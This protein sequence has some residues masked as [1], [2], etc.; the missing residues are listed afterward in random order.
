MTNKLPTSSKLPS[1]AKPPSSPTILRHAVAPEDVRRRNQSDIFFD[2]YRYKPSN[3]YVRQLLYQVIHDNEFSEKVCCYFGINTSEHETIVRHVIKNELIS[4]SFWDTY[5][6]NGVAITSEIQR[7]YNTTLVFATNHDYIPSRDNNGLAR[8]NYPMDANLQF[9]L[10]NLKSTSCILKKHHTL[11]SSSTLP[12]HV[13]P[14]NTLRKTRSDGL[15]INKSTFYKS[16]PEGCQI[17]SD[18][19][20]TRSE[21]SSIRSEGYQTRSE[22]CRIRSEDYQM[23]SEDC[24][25]KSNGI[26][27][28]N[29]IQVSTNFQ[30]DP[31]NRT[32]MVRSV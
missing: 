21:G 20:Q 32:I 3:E 27:A 30:T 5:W 31:E 4:E 13:P 28:Q 23:E 6:G 11:S 1:S 16:S 18:V 17:K 7:V 2:T 14:A 25:L 22:D 12:I 9:R 15:Q 10:Q 19:Y 8:R 24:Q 26:V 29:S